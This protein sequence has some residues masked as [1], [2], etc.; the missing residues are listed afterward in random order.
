VHSGDDAREDHSGPEGVRKEADDVLDD[1]PG[2]GFGGVHHLD[3]PISAGRDVDVVEA[4]AGPSH[5][6][7]RRQA[8]EKGLVDPGVGADEQGLDLRGEFLESPALG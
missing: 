4:D 6:P 1:G 7:K 2:V 8:S 3:P 5:H